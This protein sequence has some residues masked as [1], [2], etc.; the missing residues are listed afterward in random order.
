MKPIEFVHDMD[1][2]SYSSHTGDA[3][4]GL[5]IPA[6]M[7]KVMDKRDWNYSFEQ[8]KDINSI[9]N[10]PWLDD[11]NVGKYFENVFVYL[12]CIMYVMLAI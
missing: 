10:C 8:Q 9:Y 6:K 2:Y 3:S 4:A 12:S 7:F 11:E 1:L 5:V